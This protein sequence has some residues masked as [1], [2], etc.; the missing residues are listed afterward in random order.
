[1]NSRDQKM[2]FINFPANTKY[3]VNGLLKLDV[4]DI[5]ASYLQ[6]FYVYRI[7]NGKL[8]PT[9]ASYDHEEEV[10]TI[11]SRTM[12]RFVITDKQFSDTT[13]VETDNGGNG[14]NG[15]TNGGSDQGTTTGPVNP[16]TGSVL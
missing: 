12:G 14:T 8:I 7:E 1:M 10:L 5:S 4:E 2:E 13:V 11:S 3:Y 6:K 15:G 9:A 16:S